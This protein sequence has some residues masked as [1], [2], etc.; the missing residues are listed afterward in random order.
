MKSHGKTVY[1]VVIS[2]VHD[3]R[4]VLE[5][6]REYHYEKLIIVGDLYE[7]EQ[8]IEEEFIDYL[9]KNREKIVYI[10]GNH[11]PSEN[12]LV[13]KAICVEVVKEYKWKLSGKKFCAIHGHQFDKVCFIFSE[14]L[15]DKM[16]L[17]LVW[18]LKIIN[19]KGLNVAKWVDY[20]H[21]KFSDHI[22]KKVRRYAIK[23]CSDTIICG[24]THIPLHIVFGSKNGK[25]IN[26]FNCG[27]CFGDLHTFLTID[28]NGTTELH[29][30]SS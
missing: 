16:F 18:A 21:I 28:E 4:N 12:N 22:A 17:Y 23:H 7:E 1:A 8:E 11:D 26:Y 20:F 15:I 30:A 6:L 24:H 14:P 19:I 27:G 29:S 5:T 2:D 13:G 9:R 3:K 25:K 10:D